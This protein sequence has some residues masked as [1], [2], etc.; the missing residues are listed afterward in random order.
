MI[1]GGHWE[2][3]NPLIMFSNKIIKNLKETCVCKSYFCWISFNL[4]VVTVYDKRIQH[5][6]CIP[7]K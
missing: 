1:Q 5:K 2:I 6:V 7:I 4:S 3:E